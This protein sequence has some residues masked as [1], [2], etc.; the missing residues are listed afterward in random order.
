[1]TLSHRMLGQLIGARR[2]TV[3]TALSELV[4]EGE[5]QRRDDGTWLLTGVPVGLPEPELARVVPIR[6]RLLP[7]ESTTALHEASVRI[8]EVTPPARPVKVNAVEM[9][10][11]T[12]QAAE[13]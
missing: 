5:L 9:Q 6:R 2:P 4:K 3:S 1:M 11:P 13:T 12:E 10:P 7:A 8:A